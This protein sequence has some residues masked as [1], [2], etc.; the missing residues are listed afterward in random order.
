MSQQ[1]LCETCQWFDPK[2]TDKAGFCRRRTP[3]PEEHTNRGIWPMVK[4]DDWC[5]KYEPSTDHQF[6]QWAGPKPTRTPKPMPRSVDGM[7]IREAAQSLLESIAA[8]GGRPLVEHCIIGNKPGSAVVSVLFGPQRAGKFARTLT[9][10]LDTG[11]N[12]FG[13][14]VVAEQLLGMPDV[15]GHAV[16]W[17]FVAR[18]PDKPGPQPYDPTDPTD[19]T[20]E[21]NG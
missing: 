13:W 19:P 2:H 20:G 17:E 21:D 11:D 8:D 5:G 18:L 9:D 15:S 6:E 10:L 1:P 16:D 14:P 4:H 7:N 12:W 3:R